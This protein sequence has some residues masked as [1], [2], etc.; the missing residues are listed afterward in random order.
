MEK[1]SKVVSM[2]PESEKK[3][4]EKLSY[5]Q[6]EQVAGNLNIQC[7]QLQNSLREAQSVIAGFNVVELLLSI[8]EKGEYFDQA[9]INR[10]VAKIQDGVTTMLDNTEESN[11]E[12]VN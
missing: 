8:I 5:E 6:L 7:R 4:S 2:T 1:K 12:E 3:T 10:C 11:K 9:F